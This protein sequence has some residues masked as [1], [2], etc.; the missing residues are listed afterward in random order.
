VKQLG[1]SNIEK[2]D[3]EGSKSIGPNTSRLI[4][5]L[6][7]IL[8]AFAPLAFSYY[9][10]YYG[11]WDTSLMITAV[12]WTVSWT[13]YGMN[14]QLVYPGSMMIIFPFFLLRLVLPYQIN[15]YYQS[16]TTR[17]RTVIAAVIADIPFIILSIPVLIISLIGGGIFV[18]NGPFPLMMIVG[19]LILWRKP[20]PKAQV[21]WDGVERTRS[22]WEEEESE[23]PPTKQSESPW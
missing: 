6:T 5:I 1:D 7:I 22:W 16:R 15:K 18:I 23:D 2:I 8:A 21:P 11:F 12:L 9:G 4:V 3:I 14:F 10:S 20:M 17:S 19:L 13:Q